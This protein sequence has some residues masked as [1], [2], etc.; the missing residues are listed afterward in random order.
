LGA[1][2]ADDEGAVEYT[3][4]FGG[5]PQDV[6]IRTS[7]RA[8]AAGL[9][10]FVRDLVADR[11]YQ[12]GMTILVDHRALDASTLTAADVRALADAVLQLDDRIG[13]SKV[14]IVVPN[15]LT[16]GFARM[17]ELQAEAAQVRSRVFYGLDDALTWLPAQG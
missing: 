6:T 2:E 11:R 13:A 17:Y 3:I 14:A 9:I 12:P 16:Y 8:D 4:E 15:P 5:E 1:E 10:G 7:G